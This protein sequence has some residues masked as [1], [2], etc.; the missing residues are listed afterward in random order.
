[1]NWLVLLWGCT[2]TPS[3]DSAAPS[4]FHE[5]QPTI[6]D[7]EWG[8]SL[9]EMEWEY[10]VRTQQWTGAGW[11]RMAKSPQY[12]ELHRIPS[13]EAAGNGSR[14]R[15]YLSL[16]VAQDWRTASSGRS[17][18]FRC[19]D[20][21]VL[22]YLITVYDTSGETVTDCR[23]WGAD[24]ELWLRMESVHDCTTLLE[25]EGDTAEQ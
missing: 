4:P 18:A 19:R 9:E 11:L 17:T 12:S 5:G 23:T 20:L 13:V 3:L 21:S 22:S 16:D 1:M 24:P 2:S 25:G 7:V 8:C 10:T 15:L 14:D 6:S